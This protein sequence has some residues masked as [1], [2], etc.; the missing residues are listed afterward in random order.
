M[1]RVDFMKDAPK[2]YF[3][4]TPRN[5]FRLK[6]GYIVKYNGCKKDENGNIMEVYA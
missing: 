2:K 4:R 3:R 5:E 1:T 6:T